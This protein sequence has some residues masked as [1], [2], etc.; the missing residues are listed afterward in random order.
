VSSMAFALPKQAR[1]LLVPPCRVNRHYDAAGFT[2]RCGL[3][4]CHRLHAVSS[5]RFDDGISPDAGSQLPGTLTSPRTGL[6]P[7]GRPQLVARL[8]HAN[9]LVV[10]APK[11]LD[12]LRYVPLVSG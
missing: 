5:L 1:L 6:A 12:A 2:R 11:L 8:H 7:V 9:L 3:V 10:M 4:S